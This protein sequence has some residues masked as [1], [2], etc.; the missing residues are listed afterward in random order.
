MT[1][2]EPLSDR[3]DLGEVLGI[4]GMSEVHRARDL[5]LNRDVAVKLLRLE[6]AR[7]PVAYLRF[8]REAQ[9]TAALNHPSIVAIHDT[10][11]ANT[12]DGP[13][14]YIVMEYVAG[15]TLRDMLRDAG[16]VDV[17]QALGIVADA[18]EALDF[19][20]RHGIVHRDVK[21]AN[22]MVSASGVV[23]VMDFGIART[24][25]DTG[26]RL[27][28][29][30]AVVGTANYLS[31]EQATGAKADAR[32]DVYA[33]GCV[34]YELLTGKS[35]FLGDTPVA[36]AYQH[37]RQKP[38]PPSA[39]RAAVG[40]DVDAVV[41]KALAK[42]PES[43][44]QS[45][46]EMRADL[47]RVR[48]GAAPQAAPHPGDHLGD[49]HGGD[50]LGGDDHDG[51]VG[52]HIRDRDDVDRIRG[53]GDGAPTATTPLA[54]VAATSP[55][56]RRRWLAAGAVAAVI[57]LVSALVIGINAATGDVRVPNV[58]DLSY[59]EAAAKLRTLGL[60]T[61][62]D[63]A[64]DPDV[65]AGRVARTDPAA[66]TEV[67][68]DATVTIVVSS[69]PGDVAVPDVS[70]TNADAAVA[71]LKANGFGTVRQTPG[72]STPEQKGLVTMTLP[73]AGAKVA[74]TVP[75]TVVVGAGPQDVPVPNVDGQTADS[76][77]TV[78]TAAGFT[79]VVPVQTD[80]TLPAGRVIGTDPPAGQ[81]TAVDQVVQLRVSLG[82]QIVTPS[83][84]GMFYADALNLLNGLGHTGP[85]LNGGDVPGA[86][87]GDKH[88]VVRQ[89]PP[90][91]TPI[92][93]GDAVTAYYGS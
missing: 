45:A 51:D 8:R 59:D 81:E 82:N 92:G 65:S 11:E 1:S 30:A 20:H 29:T 32:S 67:A 60:S 9:H 47:L 69:G 64:S 87:D 56:R 79:N 83:L 71:T 39:R 36:V 18:C 27:T 52:H 68:D 74:T 49:D 37:V 34:L 93:K 80:S 66:D 6:L 76:A 31:P 57:A 33:L 24:L 13:V 85:F 15:R 3:Y 26:G 19:S 55:G 88:R 89:D 28:Q 40:P 22:I 75:I 14:P 73:P 77:R 50:H 62:R 53:G 43:R 7:D 41:L 21:P 25:G 2:G 54:P 16:P 90:A 35:P 12:A 5:R 61:A 91:G 23:K 46:E 17:G 10:G 4:G 48:A 86:Q 84:L 44:Y 38:S 63:E 42:K 72:A 78:L 58:R 70:G